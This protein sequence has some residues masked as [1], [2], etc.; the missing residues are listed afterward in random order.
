MLYAYIQTGTRTDSTNRKER[1]K[2]PI[3]TAIG[4]CDLDSRTVVVA[5]VKTVMDFV[6]YVRRRTSWPKTVEMK[7]GWCV[8]RTNEML[9]REKDQQ[10]APLSH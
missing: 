3:W 5:A 10:D 6:L 8:S 4:G 2:G 7:N 1:N 9:I